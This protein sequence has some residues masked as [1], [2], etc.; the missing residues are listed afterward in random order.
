[1]TQPSEQVGYLST[2]TVLDLWVRDW[3]DVLD[4]NEGLPKP[5]V[6]NLSLWLTN[7]LDRAC[8][9]HAAVDEFAGEIRDL[10]RSIR[11][12]V[13]ISEIRPEQLDIPCPR[14]DLLDLHRLPGEDRVECGSCG[15]LLT[16]E[17]YRRWVK[18]L[19]AD[20]QNGVA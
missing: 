12:A 7:R 10:A 4:L 19:A 1:M 3:R 6:A 8:A 13:G 20:V 2:A 11:R 17:E 16:E 18:L 5:T 15:V 9:D 14:C